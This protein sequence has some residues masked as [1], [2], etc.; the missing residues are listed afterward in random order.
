MEN[1]WTEPAQ[2]NHAEKTIDLRFNKHAT[3][4]AS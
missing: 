1:N 2:T 3:D 4:I